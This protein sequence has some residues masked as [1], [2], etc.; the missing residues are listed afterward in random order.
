MVVNTS[1]EVPKPENQGQ[2]NDSPNL[3][4]SVFGRRVGKGQDWHIPRV[5]FCVISTNTWLASA[6]V[7]SFPIEC[8]AGF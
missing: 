1:F 5:C 4:T 7:F 2:P 3:G 6:Y 8:N